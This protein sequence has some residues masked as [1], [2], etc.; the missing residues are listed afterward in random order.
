MTLLANNTLKN[1]PRSLPSPPL[2]ITLPSFQI[3]RSL[4]LDPVDYEEVSMADLNDHMKQVGNKL[5]YFGISSG[6]AFEAFA[7]HNT[8]YRVNA[9]KNLNR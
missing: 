7:V 1:W 5:V 4:K 6:G 9:I 2:L 3:A 8:F